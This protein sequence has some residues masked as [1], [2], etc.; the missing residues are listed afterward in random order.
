MKKI[1][2]LFVCVGAQKAGTTWLY[3]QFAGHPDFGQP[4]FK[5]VHYF[6]H[7]HSGTRYLNDLRLRILL[8]HCEHKREEVARWM[9]GDHPNRGSF[10]VGRVLDAVTQRIDDDWYVDALTTSARWAMD[11]SPGYATIGW[12]GFAHMSRLALE[13]EPCFI[14][15]HPVERA[16]SS[17]VHELTQADGLLPSRQIEQVS[18]DE[19]KAM[20]VD[21]TK[22]IYR[23]TDYWSTLQAM[24][25]V[26]GLPRV[27]IAFHDEIRAD[28]EALMLRL[29][30]RL[31]VDP[32]SMNRESLRKAVFESPKTK[33]P[34]YARKM[35]TDRWAPMVR[36]LHQDVCHVPLA[37]HED[38]GI[39]RARKARSP[40]SGAKPPV[41]PPKVPLP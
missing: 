32:D 23:Y 2:R 36:R 6:D 7:V 22:M 4:F 16:W 10:E 29:F 14:M 11:F 31:E 38:F 37:W 39:P 30:K 35:L 3:E 21:E 28:P 34:D 9:H 5:E 18:P 41:Q 20:L 19:V 27:L 1:E 15:R 17:L 26:F 12:E 13:V 25:T 40:R 8:W 24:S 33:I